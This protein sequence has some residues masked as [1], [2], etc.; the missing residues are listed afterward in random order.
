M[1]CR[2]KIAIKSHLHHL[3]PL[4]I[5][6]FR[7]LATFE[8][9]EHDFIAMEDLGVHGFRS[10]D[11]QV[12]MD[13]DHCQLALA[14][15]GKFHGLSHAMR[16]IEPETFEKL[17]SHMVDIYYA[18]PA[19]EWYTEMASLQIDVARDAVHRE[20]PGSAIEQ[21][22]H[23]FTEKTSEFYSRMIELTHTVNEFA[24]VGHGDCW[25]PNFMFNYE[26][27]DPAHPIPK[28]MKM[29]DFQLVRLGSCALDIS[30][31]LY[32]CTTEQLRT[33]HYEDMLQWYYGGVEHVLKQFSLDPSKVFP[34]SVLK[35]E[36]KAF[37]RF[38]VGMAMESL[39]LSI[40]SDDETA[41]M[42]AIEGS[43]PLSLPEVWQLKPIDSQEG[44]RRLAN[45]FKHAVEQGY[46]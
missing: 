41:D 6:I 22:M 19:R 32:S 27:T 13:V 34:M 16:S 37:A 18:E 45:V 1:N 38:G 31:F 46:L 15:L 7:C 24:V 43:Q 35:D 30:F 17:T 9:G 12:G 11:R 14:S 36:L 3:S 5:S 40:M 42:D 33:D 4:H 29:I 44:R 39:P 20:Y 8:D 2:G 28:R 25:L 23:K 10:A 21:R 26:D